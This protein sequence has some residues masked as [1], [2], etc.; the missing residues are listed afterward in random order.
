M[1]IAVTHAGTVPVVQLDP[2]FVDLAERDAFEAGSG[3]QRG[4][5][6]AG[7]SEQDRGVAGAGVGCPAVVSGFEHGVAASGPDPVMCLVEVQRGSVAGP[8]PQGGGGLDGVVEPVQLVEAGG[9]DFGFQQSQCTACLDGGQLGWV[10]EQ[11]NRR[12]ALLGV[13]DEFGELEGAGHAG[14]VDQ[15]HVTGR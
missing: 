15:D 6:T 12:A 4:H 10:A 11:P 5:V 3:V 1:T 2:G 8:Q 14:L 9:A 7:R 13:L